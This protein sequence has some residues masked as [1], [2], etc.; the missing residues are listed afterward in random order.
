LRKED[1][2]FKNLLQAIDHFERTDML[3]IGTNLLSGLATKISTLQNSE[4][5]DL[6]KK[7]TIEVFQKAVLK[8]IGFTSKCFEKY[9][10]KDPGLVRNCLFHSQRHLLALSHLFNSM[11]PSVETERQ[12]KN[13]ENT[14]GK[15][16]RALPKNP[17]QDLEIGIRFDH[18]QNNARLKEQGRAL[19]L[20]PPSIWQRIA[21]FFSFPTPSYQG[22][23]FQKYPGEDAMRWAARP[24]PLP[25]PQIVTS[26]VYNSG[27]NT[28][29]YA[30]TVKY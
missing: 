26:S 3:R 29:R 18:A 4:A 22:A 2:R 21:K 23:S 28:Y 20:E 11:P 5:V 25:P 16:Q 9:I 27:T 30:P 19:G 12:I 13:W 1:P 6:L 8:D 7:K 24:R 15:I 17:K 10:K 14:L